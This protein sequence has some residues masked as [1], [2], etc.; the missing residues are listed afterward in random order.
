MVIRS[1]RDGFP[2]SPKGGQLASRVNGGRP[3]R[4]RPFFE[5][6]ELLKWADAYRAVDPLAE[7]V[8]N[9]R[10]PVPIETWTKEG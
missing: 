2:F 10:K 9:L 7:R 3:R 1:K 5:I 4:E 8:E 6:K